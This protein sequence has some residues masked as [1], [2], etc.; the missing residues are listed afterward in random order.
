MLPA[1]PPAEQNSIFLTE[2]SF[3]STNFLRVCGEKIN[4]CL[5]ESKLYQQDLN[6]FPTK[7]SMFGVPMINSPPLLS[8]FLIRLKQSDGSSKCSIT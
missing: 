5:G 1:I 4:R 8:F 6:A 7:L 2:K 3:F